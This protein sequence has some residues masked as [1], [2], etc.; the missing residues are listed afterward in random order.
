M[1]KFEYNEA[2]ENDPI[3]IEQVWAEKPGGGVVHVTED[4]PATTP[5]AAGEDGTYEIV[6]SLVAFELG[7]TYHSEGIIYLKKVDGLQVGNFIACKDDEN[8]VA[9]KIVSIGSQI[10]VAN[11]YR[12]EMGTKLLCEISA[13]DYVYLAKTK[14]ETDTGGYIPAEFAGNVGTPAYITGNDLKAADGEYQAVRLINGAN[15]RKETAI[16][17]EEQ[18]QAMKGIH[19]V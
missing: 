2:A 8:K 11:G 3:R 18:A 13:G 1:S 16:V 10:E 19:L 17:T 9:A 5:V 7:T 12:V 4:M 6:D 14:E 15:V